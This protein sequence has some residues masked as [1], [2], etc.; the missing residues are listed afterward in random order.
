MGIYSGN[1]FY[2]SAMCNS[3]LFSSM[4]VEL[5]YARWDHEPSFANFLPF[6]GWS[7][8][9]TKQYNDVAAPQ[10]DVN[11][12]ADYRASGDCGNDAR[13]AWE[14]MQQQREQQ[15]EEKDKQQLQQ[16]EDELAEDFTE[17]ILLASSDDSGSPSSS[18]VA[19]AATAAG[20]NCTIGVDLATPV[21]VSAFQCLMQTQGV[22]FLTVR[23]F[24]SNCYIDPHTVDTVRP[25]TRHKQQSRSLLCVV[26]REKQ[27]NKISAYVCSPLLSALHRAFSDPRCL[28]CRSQRSRRVFF[29]FRSDSA[30]LRC[31]GALGAKQQE[32]TECSSFALC[33]CRGLM[34]DVHAC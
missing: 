13:E 32:G 34:C 16:G 19:V 21:S 26:A 20:P 5:W 11:T 15:E 9:H 24:Q 18:L 30:L 22:Q 29:P 25:R 8:P 17:L 10:C 2:A 31:T 3:T 27:G 33:V 23:A 1:N 7:Q 12:D 14:R 28:G 4:G 6:G